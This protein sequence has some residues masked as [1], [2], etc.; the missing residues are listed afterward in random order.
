MKTVLKNVYKSLPL[1]KEMFSLVKM[2]WTPSPTIYRHLYFKGDFKVKVDDEHSFLINHYGFQIENELFWRGLNEA[3]E[4]TSIQLWQKLVTRADVIFDIGANTG[5][6]ALVAKS[7]NPSSKV[8]AFDP[9]KRVFERLL[10]NNKLNNY[11]IECFELAASNA[12]GDAVIYDLPFEHILSVT[13]NKNNLLPDVGVDAIPTTIKTVRLDTF[14]A[15]HE[16]NKVDLLKIDVER[17][18]FEVLDGMGVYLEQHRP[19]ML[20][21]ILENEVGE[22]VESLVSDKDYLYFRIDDEDG[23]VNKMPHIRIEKDC[24]FLLCDEKTATELML[25]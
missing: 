4:K 2:V 3:W 9:V 22:K 1:K 16:I 5:L 11:D 8:Y 6:Y 15:Q 18:E 20:A 25:L 21:E 12:D 23:S 19:N 17:H 13:V 7:L 10:E 14:I 24:N